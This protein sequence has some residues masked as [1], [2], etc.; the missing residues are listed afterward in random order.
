MSGAWRASLLSVCVWVKP[1]RPPQEAN[2]SVEEL[3]ADPAR[4]MSA[5]RE[6]TLDGV[7]RTVS[8]L[9]GLTQVTRDAAGRARARRLTDGL[10]SLSWQF[11]T[12]GLQEAHAW[13]ILRDCTTAEMAAGKVSSRRARLAFAP[14]V[15]ACVCFADP[16]RY[17]GRLYQGGGVAD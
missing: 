6:G 7:I 13:T 4:A 10:P 11:Y 9:L 12:L 15:L 3:A 8:N 17:C 2:E 16:Q 1:A 14:D 5:V